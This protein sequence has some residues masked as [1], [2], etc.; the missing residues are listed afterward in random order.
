MLGMDIKG[1]ALIMSVNQWSIEKENKS[2][3]TVWMCLS[4]S[5]TANKKGFEPIKQS[6]DITSASILA[7]ILSS[8]VKLPAICEA[9]FT[10][11]TGGQSAKPILKNI[12]KV[13]KQLEL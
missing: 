6:L 1:Q 10:L 13:I 3:F 8:N 4:E 11:V 12:D 5:S 9:T 2:G 7:P